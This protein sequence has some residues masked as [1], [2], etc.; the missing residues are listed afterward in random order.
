[1]KCF[2]FQFSKDYGATKETA[3]A[4]VGI[5]ADVEEQRNEWTK[6]IYSTSATA[7]RKHGFRQSPVLTV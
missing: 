3:F 6:V 7:T 2:C 4:F 1:M 5:L